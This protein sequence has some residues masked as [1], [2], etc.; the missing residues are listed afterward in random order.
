M[1]ALRDLKQGM[2]SNAK[3]GKMVMYSVECM[4]R[5][6]VDQVSVEE[7]AQ[8]GCIQSA[9][10]ACNQNA[11][12]HQVQHAVNTALLRA[13]R[14]DHCI[15]EVSKAINCDFSSFALSLSAHNDRDT[16]LSTTQLLGKLARAPPPEGPRNI[17][18]MKR[19]GIYDLLAQKVMECPED[20]LELLA[21]LADTLA[22]GADDPVIAQML[23]DKGVFQK[24]LNVLAKNPSNKPLARAV[25]NLIAQ[26]CL[27]GDHIVAQLKNMGALGVLAKA[28]QAIPNDKELTDAVARALAFLTDANDLAQVVASL[29]LPNQSWDALCAATARLAALTLVPAHLSYFKS[30]AGSDKLVQV[31]RQALAAGFTLPYSVDAATQSMLAMSRICKGGEHNVYGLMRAGAVA[32]MTETLRALLKA[33]QSTTD[34]GMLSQLQDAILAGLAAIQAMMTRKENMSHMEDHGAILAAIYAAM[35]FIKNEAIANALV[36][37]CV[38]ALQFPDTLSDA[39]KQAMIEAML[40]VLVHHAD[41]A[42]LVARALDALNRLAGSADEELAIIDGGIVRKAMAALKKHDANRDVVKAAL[43][44]LDLAVMLPEGLDDINEDQLNKILNKL[45]KDYGD[46]DEIC[47]LMDALKKGIAVN[48]Q[49]GAGDHDDITNTNQQAP[50]PADPLG[51]LSGVGNGLGGDMNDILNKLKQ[52]A[53][54]ET[55]TTTHIKDIQNEPPY[56]PWAN[57]PLNTTANENATPPLALHIMESFNKIQQY[58]TERRAAKLLNMFE[59]LCHQPQ[60]YDRDYLVNAVLDAIGAIA[61][62]ASQAEAA[63]VSSNGAVDAETKAMLHPDG[64]GV[65]IVLR[66]LESG[67]VQYSMGERVCDR[68]LKATSDEDVIVLSDN[69]ATLLSLVDRDSCRVVSGH[70]GLQPQSQANVGTEETP[71]QTCN[72]HVDVAQRKAAITDARK[73]LEDMR[74]VFHSHHMFIVMSMLCYMYTLRALIKR[75]NGLYHPFHGRLCS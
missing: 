18:E 14:D 74:Y 3:F 54:K 26:A 57:N 19:L 75:G 73:A 30:G 55:N 9:L 29:S 62:E 6:A 37:L 71:Y 15:N 43:I 2:D 22:T 45:K 25:A 56:A 58:L 4:G 16:T 70:S 33:A 50:T 66:D 39:T 34:P 69:F 46:D 11:K 13:C 21:A 67:I 38:A 12:T 36:D 41:N 23:I 72:P 64:S 59:V 10:T 49:G 8:S 7:I 28:L 5:M 61:E 17:A 63:F 32:A 1:K 51:A 42:A 60:T 35:P 48:I 65:S 24:L 68:I 47:D 40:G 20:D 31:L 53:G 52:L 27:A 44:A